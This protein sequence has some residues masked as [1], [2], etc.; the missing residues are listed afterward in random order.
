MQTSATFAIALLA[1]LTAISLVFLLLLGLPVLL[2]AIALLTILAALLL[3]L[4]RAILLVLP[5]FHG[6][7]PLFVP[8]IGQWIK[9]RLKAAFPQ[10]ADATTVYGRMSK[11]RPT[12]R[13]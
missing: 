3:L 10:C 12:A 13:Y 9:A 6:T 4:V 7:S 11:R 8:K 2:T 5:V 1:G